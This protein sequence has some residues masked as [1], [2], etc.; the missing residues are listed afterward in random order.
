MSGQE[1]KTALNQANEL[2]KAARKRAYHA[3]ADFMAKKGDCWWD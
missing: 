3:L 2:Y 1:H